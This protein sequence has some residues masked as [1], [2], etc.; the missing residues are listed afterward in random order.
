MQPFIRTALRT[1]LSSFNY[2]RPTAVY[3][4]AFRK[5]SYYSL[6]H[7][8]ALTRTMSFDRREFTPI[9]APSPLAVGLAFADL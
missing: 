2:T 8:S 3:S 5:P 7:V 9:W 6:I 4:C 1:R